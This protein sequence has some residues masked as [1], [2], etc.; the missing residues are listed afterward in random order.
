L[1]QGAGTG[2]WLAEGVIGDEVVD[3]KEEE[4]EISPSNCGMAHCSAMLATQQ[5]L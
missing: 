3:E 1:G 5:L 4:G 2:N